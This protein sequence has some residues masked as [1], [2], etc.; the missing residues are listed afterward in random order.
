MDP[1]TP[2]TAMGWLPFALLAAVF[3]ALTHIFGKVGVADVSSN[4]ATWVRVIVIF[5][6]TS[7]LIVCRGEWTNPAA[8]PSR[9]MLFLVLSALATG[10][11]WLC[12]FRALQLGQASQVGPVDKLS[13]IV[14]M[15]LGVV[16]LGES[17]NWRQWLGGLFIC[18]GVILVAYPVNKETVAPRVEQGGSN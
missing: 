11:S 3:A 15:L 2:S 10:A 13:V 4:M 16:F 1:A 17:L 18:A 12:G 7:A 9:T 14:I 8:L 5:M 6:M